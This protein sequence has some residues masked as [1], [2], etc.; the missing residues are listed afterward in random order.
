MMSNQVVDSVFLKIF[1]C[2]YKDKKRLTPR[3]LKNAWPIDIFF[4][5][6]LVFND[7][8]NIH[9]LGYIHSPWIYAHHKGNIQETFNNATRKC[10]YQNDLGF[11]SREST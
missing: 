1:R 2:W 3:S 9:E 6:E 4:K 10:T 8:G 5:N 7:D 11:H